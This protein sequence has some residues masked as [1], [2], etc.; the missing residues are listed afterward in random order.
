MLVRPPAVSIV[1]GLAAGTVFVRRQHRLA[2]PLLDLRLFRSAAFTAALTANLLS[3]FAGFGALLF[4]AQYLQLVLGL[5]PLAAGL[6]MLPASAGTVLGSPPARPS[7]T[8]CT[9]P[10][11][12]APPPCSPPPYSP[13]SSSATCTRTPIPRPAFPW[14][15]EPADAATQGPT[16]KAAGPGPPPGTAQVAMLCDGKPG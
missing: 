3:F 10:S 4:I 16:K 15:Q 12:S 5:S 6:W 1:A 7:P 11:L 9:W 13:R 14:T 2:D 8:A